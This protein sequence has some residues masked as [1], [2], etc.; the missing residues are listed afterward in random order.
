MDIWSSRAIKIE[1][2]A[3]YRLSTLQKEKNRSVC[4]ISTRNRLLPSVEMRSLPSTVA[5]SQ[6]SSMSD[7]A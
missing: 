5:L 1:M 6:R 3:Q 4:L 7:D 2:Y